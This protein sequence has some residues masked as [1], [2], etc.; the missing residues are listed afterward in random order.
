MWLFDTNDRASLLKYGLVNDVEIDIIN[1]CWRG[2][3]LACINNHIE[4]AKL[5]W[6]VYFKVLQ[7]HSNDPNGIISYDIHNICEKCCVRGY[8]KMF[9]WL[10]HIHTKIPSHRYYYYDH[11]CVKRLISKR[12]RGDMAGYIT[13]KIINASDIF[14]KICEN[15]HI[16]IADWI[17]K[18]NDDF[19][20]Y[21]K[22]DGS[23]E[24]DVSMD[25]ID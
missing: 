6:D 12:Y 14:R 4:I 25:E 24:C 2:F 23:I 8:L 1:F 15:G 19:K 18:R 22:S 7:I 9:K 13:Q 11:H 5:L 3:H 10:L 20:Y 21:I 16:D 17:S